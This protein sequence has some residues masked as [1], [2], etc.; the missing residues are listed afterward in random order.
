MDSAKLRLFAGAAA[1]LFGVTGAIALSAALAI[2]LTPVLGAAWA[3]VVSALLMLAAGFGCLYFA[4]APEE[5]LEDDISA[6]ER[7]AASALADLPF[8]TLKAFIEKNPMGAVS[9][10][11][12]A[13][14]AIGRD[15]ASAARNIQRIAAQ[16]L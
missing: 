10:A 16:L 8:D 14:F 5:P 9:L 12:G 6:V 1:A 4:I 3:V 7:Q 15:P 13:G 11:L 2:T